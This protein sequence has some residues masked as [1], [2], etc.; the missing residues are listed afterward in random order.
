MNALAFSGNDELFILKVHPELEDKTREEG[1]QIMR[2]NPEYWDRSL[3]SSAI[4]FMTFWY[5]DKNQVETDEFFTN[6]GHPIFADVIMKS[7]KLEKL[8]GLIAR[9]K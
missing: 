8:A 7:I 4:Q 6:N 3:P 2:F 1:G 9:K 5:P